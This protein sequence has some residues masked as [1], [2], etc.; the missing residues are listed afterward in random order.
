MKTLINSVLTAVLLSTA[1]FAYAADDA[2]NQ[3]TEQQ[4]QQNQTKNDSKC[5]PGVLDPNCY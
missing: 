4:D 3:V 1:V 2:Q 5:A